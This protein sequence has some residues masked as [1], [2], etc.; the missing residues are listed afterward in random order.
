MAGDEPRV[1]SFDCYGT[2]VDWETGISDAFIRT[3]AE[4]DVWLEPGAVLDLYQEI[5]HEVEAERYRP[6][7]EVLEET[8]RRIADRLGWDLDPDRASFLPESL[9]DWPVFP[10]TA[11]ALT[12][13]KARYGIAILSNVDDDLLEGTLERI[14]VEFDWTVTAQAVQSYKP[15]PAHFREAIRRAGGPER[16]LHAAQS[17]FHDIEPA[18]ELGLSVVWVN[19]Q[20]QEQPPGPDPGAVVDDVAG[21]ADWLGV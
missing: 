10:D 14:G 19:R 17:Y 15:A 5:E 4:D 20:N 16:L 13:L 1:I 2:L 12:R 8:A 3:A 18:R 7:R 21:L 11:E 6:Y 9:P